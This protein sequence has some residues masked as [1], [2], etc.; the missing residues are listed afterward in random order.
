MKYKIV[1]SDSVRDLKEETKE[2]VIA[3]LLGSDANCSLEFVKTED[4]IHVYK[5]VY[6]DV[7]IYEKKKPLQNKKLK[8]RWH[9]TR[10]RRF[11]RNYNSYLL[12]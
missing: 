9:P 2:A 3:D 5:K 11:R 4:N 7:H 12:K 6:K 1:G 8:R 10:G